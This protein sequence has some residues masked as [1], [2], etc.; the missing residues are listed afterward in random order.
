MFQRVYCSSLTDFTMVQMQ[1]LLSPELLATWP[2][3]GVTVKVYL[4]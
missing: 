3:K 2:P 4:Y 1:V